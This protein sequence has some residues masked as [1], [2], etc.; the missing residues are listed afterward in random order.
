MK[1]GVNQ[2]CPLL[3]IFA[4]LVLHR[5]LKPLATK[6]KQQ[7]D[8]QLNSGNTG[9]NGF[10]SLM[11]LFAYMDNISSMVHHKGVQFFCTEIKKLGA[12]RGC[13][14]N[15]LKTRIL[16]SCSGN[17]ILP[18]LQME[19][20]NLAAEIE[21]TLATY[22]ITKNK[23]GTLLPV[24][25]TRGFWL[26]GTPIGSPWFAHEFFDEQLQAVRAATHSLTNAIPDLHTWMK[27]FLQCTIQKLPHLLDSDTMHNLPLEYN[28]D[29]WHNWNGPLTSSIDSLSTSSYKQALK[30]P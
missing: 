11:H 26:L 16:T 25:L 9:N 8:N 22:S 14:V 12:P 29:N 19:H 3:P 23:D 27:F 17:T 28:N 24:E 4:T 7:A 5:V 1:E 18:Q 30:Q 6:L 13:F 10:R 2:G 20:S 21:Q 15:P